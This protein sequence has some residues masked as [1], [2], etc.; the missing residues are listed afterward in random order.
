MFC[1]PQNN[2]IFMGRGRGNMDTM[3]PRERWLAVLGHQQPDRLPMGFWGTPEAKQKLMRALACNDEISMQEKLYIDPIIT[4]QPLYIGPLLEDGMNMYGCQFRQI[5]YQGGVYD[6]CATHSLAQYNSIEEIE[7]HYTWPSADWFDYA[8]I[9]DQLKGKERYPIQGGGSEPFLIYCELRGLEQAYIDLMMNRDM[10]DY[11]LDKLFGFAYENTVRIYEQAQGQVTYS[12]I[13]EDFGAQESLLFSPK[14]IREIFVPR[15]KRMMDLAHESGTY[16]FFHSDGAIRKIIP[17][18]IEAGIDILNPIQWRSTGMDR[19]GLQ[20]DF[21]GQVVFHGGVDNQYTLPFGT[22]G[23]VRE[24][25]ITHIDIFGK[26]GGY[27]LAPCHNIQ[28]VSPVENI[29]AMY[30]TG[31]EFGR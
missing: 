7:D 8:V 21:G 15:M 17:D 16:V 31:Y 25:V 29:I 23:E 18:M 2:S 19:E 14:I 9:R 22:V 4:L 3:T 11:C 24:E 1:P 13:A 30:E 5:T 20:Q 6:E 26:D 28:A 27:I 10:V 12:Y